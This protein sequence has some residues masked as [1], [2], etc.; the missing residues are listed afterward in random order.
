MK[1]YVPSGYQII[2]IDT[3]DKT[4]GTGFT[5][6]T[7]D[8]KILYEILSSGKLEPKPILLKIKTSVVSLC[9]YGVIVDDTNL[10]LSTNSYAEDFSISGTKL[11]WTETEL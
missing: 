3:T 7:D 5:P 11:V 4:S 8:E 2:N 9:G 10:N 1:K 6:E